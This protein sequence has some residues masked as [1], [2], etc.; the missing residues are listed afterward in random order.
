MDACICV[1][2]YLELMKTRRGLRFSKT[3]VWAVVSGKRELEIEPLSPLRA[4]SGL[5]YCAISPVP[6]DV[7]PITG[8]SL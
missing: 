1:Y 6:C 4:T 7:F 3:G 5:N 2:V 8:S